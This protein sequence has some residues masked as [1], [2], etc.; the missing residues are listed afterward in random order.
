MAPFEALYMRKCRTSLCWGE[1]NEG[2]SIGPELNQETT[3]KIRKIQEHVKVAQSRQ[4]E[5]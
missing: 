3:E 5:C 4:K 2:L 1:L